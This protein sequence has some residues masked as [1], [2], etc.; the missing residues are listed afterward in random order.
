M[1]YKLPLLVG[2]ASLAALVGVQ[3][4]TA[5]T[6]PVGYITHN[7][8]GNAAGGSSGADTYIAPTLT[9]KND[10]VGATSVAPAGSVFTFASGVPAG[11]TGTSVAE[12]ST[13]TR[14]GWWSVIASSTATSITTVDPV[15]A[16]L[17]AGATV[18]VYKL[19]TLND[20]LG[21]NTPGL[22]ALDGVNQKPDEVQFLDAATQQ[23]T[24]AVYVTT[25]VG[26]PANGWY[27]FVDQSNL[28]GKFIYPG[29][30]IKVRRYAAA[31]KSFVSTGY[32]KTNKTE[33]DIFPQDNWVEPQ[34]AVGGTYASLNV[35]TS[36][37]P[38][39]GNDAT[40][41]PADQLQVLRANQATDVFVA[42][43]PSLGG[44]VVNFVTQADASGEIFTEGT[45]INV[46]RAASAPAGIWTVPAQVIAP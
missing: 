26:V 18:K 19:K 31:A 11:L 45:G 44:G 21:A 10:F 9:T 2:L 35:A 13:G 23:T 27:N 43:A 28:D 39:D 37:N 36:F 33:V 22:A 42:L 1:K 20:F 8:A 4:Q 15:P 40:N 34:R 32:V 14:E 29:Q 16:G 7:V 24:I 3:A 5:V 38:E 12:I 30:S 17:A 6:D 25:A 41:P 46:K